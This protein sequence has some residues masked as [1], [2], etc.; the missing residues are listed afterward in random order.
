[1]SFVDQHGK[2][3]KQLE[4]MENFIENRRADQ[5]LKKE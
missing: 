5:I 3:E 1:M 2:N 4:I